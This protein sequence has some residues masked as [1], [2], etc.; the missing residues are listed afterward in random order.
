[1]KRTY[2]VKA[3]W[4]EE[5]KVWYSESD[6]FGLHIEA[7]T[8][9][10]FEVVMNEFAGELIITNHFKPHELLDV[11]LKDVIPTIIW[12]RPEETLAAT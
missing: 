12:Q 2:Y 10:Q 4:D 7:K 8:L 5:A 3:L 11:P 6:I 9:E 1:M